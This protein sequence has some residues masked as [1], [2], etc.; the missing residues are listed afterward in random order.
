MTPDKITL[1]QESFQKVATIADQAAEIFYKNLFAL[2]PQLKSLFK[3][4]MPAQGRKLMRM[5][6]IAVKGLK[7]PETLIPAVEELGRR[8]VD[9]GVRARDYETVGQA[10][11][12]TLEQGLGADFTPPVKE[13]WSA[14]FDLLSGM[15]KKA[16]FSN[17]EAA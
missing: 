6:G 14:T 1:V 4:D 7:T 12:V 5:I 9:Y 10:L 2:D 16:A 8:H 3:A 17:Q 15:M 13:A 11:M